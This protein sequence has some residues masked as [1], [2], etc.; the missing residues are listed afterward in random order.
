[1]ESPSLLNDFVAKASGWVATASSLDKQF[2]ILECSIPEEYKQA[3][4]EHLE[5]CRKDEGL[6]RP[7]LE[8]MHS[9]RNDIRANLADLEASAESNRKKVDE[10]FQS[11]AKAV[12]A[13]DDARAKEALLQRSVFRLKLSEDELRLRVRKELDSVLE[14]ILPPIL[15]C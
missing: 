13:N 14:S 11:A 6:L 15:D 1:M 8:N 2:D 5:T 10:W 12:Q 9:L 3:L 7:F 4:R